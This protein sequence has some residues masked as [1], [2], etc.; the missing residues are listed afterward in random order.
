MIK[1]KYK[2]FNPKT[3]TTYIVRPP[4]AGHGSIKGQKLWSLEDVQKFN[5][6]VET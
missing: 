3:G 4:G 1:R 6:K 2:I 5:R